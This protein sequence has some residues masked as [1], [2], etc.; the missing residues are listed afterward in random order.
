M[1]DE[2][3]TF[4][5]RVS[6]EVLRQLYSACRALIFPSREDFGL[7]PLEAHASGCPVVA[8]GVGGVRETM[9]DGQTG[10]FFGNQD[11]G[12]SKRPS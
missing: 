5:G 7:A 1:A 2:H 11:S 8:Y 10:V 6:D 3:V 4:V 12:H 9:I